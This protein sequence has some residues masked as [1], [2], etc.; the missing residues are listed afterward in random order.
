MQ[1]TALVACAAVRAPMRSK[2]LVDFVHSPDISVPHNSLGDM[3]ASAGK[4]MQYLFVNDDLACVERQVAA[5]GLI[6]KRRVH[7]SA[8]RMI[9]QQITLSRVD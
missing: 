6:W 7:V 8:V 5:A 4:A 2:I 1:S 3:S 9:S